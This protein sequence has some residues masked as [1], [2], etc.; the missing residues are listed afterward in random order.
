MKARIGPLLECLGPS[1]LEHLALNVVPGYQDEWEEE[2]L[3]WPRRERA[4]SLERQPLLR[5]ITL[6]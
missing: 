6:S 4:L 5:A 1:A 2:R 3:D